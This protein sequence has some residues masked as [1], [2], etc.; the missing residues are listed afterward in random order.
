MERGAKAAAQADVVHVWRT[1][2]ERMPPALEGIHAALCHRADGSS[3]VGADLFGAMP[4]YYVCGEDYVVVGSSPDVFRWHPDFVAELDPAGLAGILLT[5]GL[6]GGRALLKGVRRLA[7]G[8]LLLISR[9]GA[10]DPGCAVVVFGR[11]GSRRR[12]RR[13]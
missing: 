7:A 11:R 8:A 10:P 1:L 2:P 6:V 3:I 12:C 13:P 9:D 5:N 4:I